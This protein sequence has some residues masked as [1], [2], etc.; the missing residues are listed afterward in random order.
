M[1][2]S[3]FIS[4]NFAAQTGRHVDLEVLQWSETVRTGVH[5]R[6]QPHHPN[7]ARSFHLRTEFFDRNRAGMPLTGCVNAPKRPT[8]VAGNQQCACVTHKARKK[9]RTFIFHARERSLVA[10]IPTQ[11]GP[12]QKGCCFPGGGCVSFRVI[13]VKAAGG[14]ADFLSMIGRVLLS[15]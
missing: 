13:V 2:L 8:A 12:S 5:K 9:R 11:Q 4:C 7:R 1:F 3:R 15:L 6:E 10:T 14:K